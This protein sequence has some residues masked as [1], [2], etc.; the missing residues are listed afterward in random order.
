M[1]TNAIYISLFIA[2]TLGLNSCRTAAPRLDY[3]ALARASVKLGVDIDMEDD[4]QLYLVSA[5]WIGTPYRSGGNSKRGV[6]CSGFTCQIYKQ[7]YLK[8]LERTT[9]GQMNQTRKISKGN[10]REGDLVFFSSRKSNKKVAHVGIY[11][12]N[13]RFI[14]ASTSR[15]V[16]VSNLNEQYYRTHWI[17]GGRIKL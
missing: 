2:V 9:L 17:R 15:G 10:L 1:K 13:G 14:H 5:E 12:K 7:V 11:L 16:I 8:K 6:D 3:K 4:H